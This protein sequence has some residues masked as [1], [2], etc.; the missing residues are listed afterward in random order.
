MPRRAGDAP[1]RV[2]EK[3]FTALRL[4]QAILLTERK[5]I[6]RGEKRFS[7]ERAA[8][9]IGIQRNVAIRLLAWHDRYLLA[10]H[11]KPKI[12]APPDQEP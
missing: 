12:G 6:E 11:E 1:Y 2:V 10:I 7:L 9:A 8:A 4:W 5:P 3:R